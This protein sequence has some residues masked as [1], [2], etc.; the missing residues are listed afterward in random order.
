[1]GKYVLGVGI[2]TVDLIGLVPSFPEPDGFSI[3]LEFDRQ[4]GGPVS[5]ALAALAR[6]GAD[7]MWAGKVG[8]DEFGRWI[9]DDFKSEG[10]LLDVFVDEGG[11]TPL[12]FILVDSN[13]G[14][15]SIIFHPGCSL[16]LER[17][18]LPEVLAGSKLI[19]LDGGFVDGAFQASAYGKK[20]GIKVSLDAGVPFPGMEDIF[21]QVDLFMPTLEIAR[22]LTGEEAVEDC[23]RKLQESGPGTVI[24]THG[25]EGSWGIEGKE[26]TRAE[27]VKVEAV[28]T[29][30]CGDAFH[31]AF[32]YGELQRWPLYRKLL[33]ANAYAA[34]K[35]T[36]LGGRKGLPSLEEMDVFIREK[37]LPIS[38]DQSN[39]DDERGL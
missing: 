19:H 15:R 38:S 11:T 16:L 12:S 36:R 30:G 10:V 5:N 34:L 4:I 24:I 26:I 33:F 9:M 29:T 20:H 1:M 6:L 7:T 25:D 27:A 28:D 37:E 22:N 32:L 23:L 39:E 31:G 21:K 2:A 13:T 3:M 18:L 14:N 8:G 35:A 17:V